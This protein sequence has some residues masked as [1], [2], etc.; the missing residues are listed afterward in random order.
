MIME[1]E[2]RQD[3]PDTVP[4]DTRMGL[5]IARTCDTAAAEK[6]GWGDLRAMVIRLRRDL[7]TPDGHFHA[8]LAPLEFGPDTTRTTDA[9]NLFLTS[10]DSQLSIHGKIP[11]T[12]IGAIV[13]SETLANV[14]DNLLPGALD[15]VYAAQVAAGARQGRVA[16]GAMTSGW[17]FVLTT[18]RHEDTTRIRVLEPGEPWPETLEIGSAVDAVNDTYVSLG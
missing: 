17:R 1:L 9:I 6:V 18:Y 11:G 13:L 2:S 10:M 14:P 8:G 3:I 15:E 5:L 12:H 7:D 16:V 4:E